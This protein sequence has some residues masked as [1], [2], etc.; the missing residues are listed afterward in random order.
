MLRIKASPVSDID[1]NKYGK[2]Y[3]MKSGSEE[4]V[5]TIGEGFEDGYTKLPLLDS[6]ASLGLTNGTQLP[7]KVQ[8][9][10]RH[11]HTQEALFSLKSPFVVAIANSGDSEQPLA[12]DIISILVQP[13]EVIVLDKGIW[14]DACHGINHSVEY[15][16]MA[17]VKGDGSNQWIDIK[18]GPIELII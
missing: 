11:L 18:E 14:H 17:A 2:Y 16:W 7:C 3:N 12:S 10:E 8:L 13:G 5:R 6:L 15:F 1:F 4:I 9:M